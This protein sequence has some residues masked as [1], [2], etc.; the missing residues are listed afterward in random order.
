MGR[1]RTAA[2]IKRQA[3]LA[4][5]RENYYRTKATST[6]TTVKKREI[7]SLVYGSYSLKVGTI[8]SLFKVPASKAAVTFFGGAAGLGLRLPTT[9]TDPVSAK[10]RNFKPAQVHAMIGTSTPTAKV[11]PWGTRVIKY[12]TATTGTSQA[13]YSAPVSVASGSVTYDLVDA[14]ATAIFNTTKNS[15][16]DLDYARFYLTA[17]QFSNV[18]N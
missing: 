6:L 2:Q 13:H 8:S 11:S 7:D 9:I 1:R 15:L 3:D 10:P 5:A 17:E 4:L 12:S 18:K 16:G 14:R